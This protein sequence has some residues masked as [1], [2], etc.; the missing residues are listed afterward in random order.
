MSPWQ[1]LNDL[2]PAAQDGR[3]P[4]DG[5]VPDLRRPVETEAVVP[6]IN[7]STAETQLSC[8][9][10]RR[11]LLLLQDAVQINNR[12]PTGGKTTSYCY[13]DII[14]E[15]L[16]DCRYLRCRYIV[17][18]SSNVELF[19]TCLCWHVTHCFTEHVLYSLSSIS[20]KIQPHKLLICWTRLPPLFRPLTYC[21]G[22]IF[23]TLWYI[24]YHLVWYI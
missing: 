3:A 24:K 1:K 19:L 18:K 4:Q 6:T 10:S 16:L 14:S 7:C 13:R 2:D 11:Q 8:D 20:I 12:T 15:R 21:S 23:Q 9:H 22:G 5:R 17:R